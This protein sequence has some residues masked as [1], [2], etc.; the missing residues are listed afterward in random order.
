MTAQPVALRPPG[1]RHEVDFGGTVAVPDGALWGAQTQRA[2]EAF[3]ISDLRLPRGYDT[4]IDPGSPALS[5][6]QRQLIALARAFYGHPRLLVLDEPNSNLDREGETAL[7]AALARAKEAGIT[8]V[9]IAHRPSIVA[10]LDRLL[11]LRGGRVGMYGPRAEVLE[12]TS[13]VVPFKRPVIGANVEAA[14]T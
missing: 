4:D 10:G 14:P 8:T 9:V 11:V 5:G 1:H 3:T 2:I 7:L 12:R 13:G 6:G